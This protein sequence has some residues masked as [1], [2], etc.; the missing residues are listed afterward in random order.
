M[1]RHY[2]TKEQA[3]QDFLPNTEI[4]MFDTETNGI[5]DCSEEGNPPNKD[6]RIIE[7]AALKVK[8]D[9]NNNGQIIDEFHVYMKP[10]IPVSEK[11]EKLTGITNE[12]LNTC[13]TEEHYKEEIF[14]FFGIHPNIAAYNTP[15]DKWFMERLYERLNLPKF[16]PAKIIDVFQMSKSILSGT[17]GSYNDEGRWS[18]NL[19]L[20]TCVHHFCLDKDIQF[21][22]A[23]DDVK[24]TLMLCNRYIEIYKNVPDGY[25]D[26]TTKKPKLVVNRVSYWEKKYNDGHELKRIYVEYI[27]NGKCFY[28]LKRHEWVAERFRFA[29]YD[30]L[31][32][33]RQVFQLTG[34]NSYDEF[35]NWKGTVKR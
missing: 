16:E 13:Y 28:D 31:N 26:S 6:L 30:M 10:H 2:Y 33:E 8:V 4:I 27:G 7:L 14:N 19:K 25:F 1:F 12:M 9:E 20:G 22:S 32:F 15:F 23:I 3:F 5:P 34:V 24:A 35:E 18:Y 17:V 21:H 11:I 29:D